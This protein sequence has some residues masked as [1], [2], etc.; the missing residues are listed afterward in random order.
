MIE[1]GGSH[2]EV[3]AALIHSFGS[4]PN[5]QIELY[6]RLQRFGIK[7]I[8]DQFE[9]SHPLPAEFTHKTKFNATEKQP[10]ILVSTTCELDS[11]E[12]DKEFTMLM[13]KEQTYL[14]CVV[15][16]ADRWVNNK[17]ARIILPWVKKGLVDFLC[18]SKHTQTFLDAELKK[19]DTGGVQA[20]TRHFIP[21]FPVDLTKTV[22]DA[23][24]DELSFAL[25][26]NYD[27]SRRDYKKI[28]NHLGKFLNSS[29]PGEEAADLNDHD[30]H[31]DIQ[32]HLLGH[33]RKP[34]VPKELEPH[35]KFDEGL[36]YLNF[37][38]IISRT[39][40]LLPGFANAE[41]LDRKASS[42][43]PASLIAGTPLVA[44]QA[45]L[46]AYTYLPPEAVWLQE[47]N[48]E[49]FDVIG[50]ILAMKPEDR[51]KKKEAVRKANEQRVEMNKGL[52]AEWMRE[53][54]AKVRKLNEKA[55]AAA[56]PEVMEGIG[57]REETDKAAR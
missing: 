35:V 48:E 52:V 57:S 36:E 8:F 39:F 29:T 1:V 14:F 6:Q 13:E 2:D 47:E 3:I 17:S 20:V 45:I 46:D 18:L 7:D 12:K 44:T 40:A 4:Q 43:V 51:K 26:G 41:Y 53:G 25:Q 31:P 34:E 42:T 22:T 19:W 38:G 54:L 27:G 16:H 28:F 15:H 37:Y 50:K 30:S 23:K 10:R 21:V 24:E 49:D 32:L 55:D 11:M 33:G 56:E 5:V 9:L